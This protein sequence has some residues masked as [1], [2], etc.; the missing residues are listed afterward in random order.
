M[1]FPHIK[2]IKKES[3]YIIKK[4]EIKNTEQK[5]LL[6]PKID[7]VFKRIFGH[8][9]NESIAKSFIG[10][11]LNRNI[12]DIVLESDSSLPKDMLDDKVGILDIKAKI[13]NHIN[14][15]IEMQ[16]VDKK[17]IEKRMWSI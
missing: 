13:D 9:G 17:N 7:Y 1:I 6:N 15:D 14:C 4:E 2:I 16:I 10:S 3:W 12:T 5:E 11:V 8:Q